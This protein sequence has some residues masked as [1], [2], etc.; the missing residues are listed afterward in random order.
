MKRPTANQM[1]ERLK[2]RRVTA[3]KTWHPRYE[4][5]ELVGF[6]G[7]RTLRNG[8]FGQ[9]EVVL[10]HVPYEGTWTLSGVRIIQLIDSSMI[11]RGAPVCI[12]FKGEK[13]LGFDDHDGREKYMKLFELFI[14]DGEPMSNADMAAAGAPA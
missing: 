2:W 14:T 10:V 7:G 8:K 3:P 12:V 11:A 1:R 6:Y 13:P 5:D 9:Y 4:G